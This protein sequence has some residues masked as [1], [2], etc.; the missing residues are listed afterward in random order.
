MG[1][2]SRAPSHA[3]SLTSRNVQWGAKKFTADHFDTEEMR[4]LQVSEAVLKAW[5]VTSKMHQEICEDDREPT[6]EMDDCRQ[7]I[8]LNG[9]PTWEWTIDELESMRR[10]RNDDLIWTAKKQ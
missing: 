7:K 6:P 2:E 3:I 4:E 1:A 5:D 9:I 8:V 10:D